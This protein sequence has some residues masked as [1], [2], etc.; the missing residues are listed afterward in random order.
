MRSLYDVLHPELAGTDV[1]DD[2]PPR[3]KLTAKT[4]SKGILE[5]PEYRD[6]LF[7]RITNDT[8]PSAVECR[9]LDHVFGK[10]VEHVE[11]RERLIA[12]ENLTEEYVTQK[13]LRVQRI[14][15]LLQSTRTN[16]EEPVTPS[17]GPPFIH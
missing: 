6:S 16:D 12:P 3:H 9:I 11:M 8:L 10:P 17:P 15:G 4:F 5:S 13:L 7:R 1:S 2:A 14:L